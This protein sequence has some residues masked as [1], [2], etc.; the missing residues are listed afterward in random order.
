MWK[1]SSENVAMGVRAPLEALAVCA[2]P[3]GLGGLV[4]AFELGGRSAAAARRTGAC[5]K[6]VGGAA[7]SRSAAATG[8]PTTRRI[9]ES[10]DSMRGAPER[11]R[12]EAKTA[13]GFMAAPMVSGELL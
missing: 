6:G 7:A 3:P 9:R 5:R 12:M 11:R 1:D 4:G 2:S 13:V 10:P 8:G